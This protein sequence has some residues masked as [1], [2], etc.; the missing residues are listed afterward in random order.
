MIKFYFVVLI[1]FWIDI[2]SVI[3]IPFKREIS[4]IKNENPESFY[5]F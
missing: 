2:T 5:N 3:I 1:S 4:D